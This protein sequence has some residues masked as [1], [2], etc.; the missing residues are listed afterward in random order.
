MKAL[1]FEDS[2]KNVDLYYNT[3]DLIQ[4]Q[5]LNDNINYMYKTK[6]PIFL[7]IDT[8]TKS[9]IMSDPSNKVVSTITLDTIT[10]LADDNPIIIVAA[11]LANDETYHVDGD[12]LSSQLQYLTL[13]DRKLINVD[14][15]NE[16]KDC[17]IIIS[18]TIYK[19]QNSN[20]YHIL[21]N[22]NTVRLMVQHIDSVDIDGYGIDYVADNI[23]SL[24]TNTYPLTITNCVI[25]I[26]NT[27]VVNKGNKVTIDCHTFPTGMT[28][29]VIAEPN[30]ELVKSN[31]D[32]I[33][34]DGKFTFTPTTDGY[35]SVVFDNIPYK[36]TTEQFGYK[37]LI[38]VI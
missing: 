16:V 14:T 9:L 37:F 33:V 36:L 35:F 6:L 32:I 15:K 12:V 29:S 13:T 38:K 19:L 20:V 23:S 18:Y 22:N 4:D 30:T 2:Y 10:S 5:L 31:Y 17:N 34:E 27:L 25:Q 7:D 3:V 21:L 28:S 11:V 24:L 1:V 8:A 26:D